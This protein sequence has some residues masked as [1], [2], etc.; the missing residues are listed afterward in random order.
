MVKEGHEVTVFTFF[1]EKNSFF[2]TPPYAVVESKTK[3]KNWLALQI[4]IFFF[5]GK[6]EMSFDLFAFEGE[7]FIWGAGLY[8]TLWGRTPVL[9]H[10]NGPIFSIYEHG[11]AFMARDKTTKSVRTKI[12]DWLRKFFE[13]NV[14][15]N[16]ANSIDAFT[17]SSPIMRDWMVAFGIDSEKIVVLS[18]FVDLEPFLKESKT[19]HPSN[20]NKTELIYVGRL[21]PEKGVDTLLAAINEIDDSKNI[22]VHIVGDGREKERLMKLAKEYGIENKVIFYGW[23][24]KETLNGLYHSSLIFVHPARWAEPLGLTIPEAMASGLP[25]IVPEISGSV[26]AAGKAGITFKNGNH[27]DL[28]D[29]I[30]KLITDKILRENLANEAKKEAERF[31]YRNSIKPL[32]NL[33]GKVARQT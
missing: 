30:E 1:P 2:E 9:L 7:H 16:L 32:E 27:K 25:V 6:H 22:L 17:I 23:V 21:A 20:Y 15:L 5:L 19:A 24:D 8:R 33:F 10:F 4:K 13:K 3:F 26:W 29:K 28:K 14:G 31:D 11:T 18:D 12:S